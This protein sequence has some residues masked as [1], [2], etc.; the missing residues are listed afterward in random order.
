MS[1]IIVY[2]TCKDESEAELIANHLVMGGFAACANIMAPHKAVYVWDGVPE[3][4]RE[5][6]MIV[7]TRDSLFEKVR[8]EILS[9]HSYECPCIV[10]WPVTAGH[11]P[12]LRW[13]EAQ[14]A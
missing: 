4:G 13:I 10:S 14:T 9:L 3:S 8:S 2:V 5:V 6:A 12:F 11:E 1:A 7:K